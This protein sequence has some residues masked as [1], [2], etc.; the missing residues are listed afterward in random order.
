MNTGLPPTPP[1]ARAG[2]LTPPGITRQA[3]SNAVSL[4]ARDFMGAFFVRRRL[5]FQLVQFLEGEQVVKAKLWSPLGHGLQVL[6][7]P[8]RDSWIG[9]GGF[10]RAEGDSVGVVLRDDILFPVD[11]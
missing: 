8:F 9:L 1:N 7:H 2:L 3:P 10:H 11:L 6:P 4:M 5:L